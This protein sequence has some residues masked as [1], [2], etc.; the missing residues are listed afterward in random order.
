MSVTRSTRRNKFINGMRWEDSKLID[1]EITRD[2][3]KDDLITAEDGML[4]HKNV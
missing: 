2:E 3:S 4:K 1:V